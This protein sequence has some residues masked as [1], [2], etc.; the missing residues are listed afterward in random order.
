[1][2]RKLV[3]MFVAATLAGASVLAG[4]GSRGE[5]LWQEAVTRVSCRRT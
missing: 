2:K 1:M 4:P 5:G 3:S